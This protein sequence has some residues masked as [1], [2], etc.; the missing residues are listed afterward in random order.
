MKNGLS[1]FN[2]G[3]TAT[4]V[5]DDTPT[6]T[7]TDTPVGQTIA[8]FRGAAAKKAPL[9]PTQ[10]ADLLANMQDMIDSRQ[11]PMA[12]FN[13]GLERAAAWG[14]GGIQGPSAA[15]NQLNQ[16][17]MAEQKSTFE[18]RQQM[19]AYRAAQ[20]QA[21]ADAEQVGKFTTPS[22]TGGMQ[23]SPEAQ[24]R[25]DLERNPT[26]RLA[27]INEDLKTRGSERAKAEFNPA[28]LKAEEYVY[29][30]DPNTNK[31]EAKQV[32]LNTYLDL[33]AKG[34]IVTEAEMLMGKGQKPTA[35]APTTTPTTAPTTA[36]GQA[37]TPSYLETP[38]AKIASQIGTTTGDFSPQEIDRLRVVESGKDPFA[39]NKDSKA[40]GPY[41][42][43]PE[44]VQDL[45]KRGIKFNPFDAEES[46]TVA[47]NELNRLTKLL[48]SKELALASYGG[49]SQ[50]DPTGYIGK[51]LVTPAGTVIAPPATEKPSTKPQATISEIKAE[52]QFQEDYNKGVAEGLSKENATALAKFKTDTNKFAISEELVTAKRIQDLAKNNPAITG[53]M[54]NAGLMPAIAKILEGGVGNFGIKE[55]DEALFLSKAD[56]SRLS[57]AERNELITYMA[58]I[59]LKAASLIKGQGQITEGEREILKRAS[60]S[61]K[62]P[63]EAVFKKARMLEA[64]AKKHDEMRE[65][66]AKTPG[67]AKNRNFEKFMEENPQIQKLHVQYR[68]EL[69]EILNEKVDFS[70][71]RAAAGKTKPVQHPKEVQA[72]I[73]RNKPGA[74]Q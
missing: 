73:D 54:Q 65:I 12:S 29:I 38:A 61:I 35:T 11:G 17:E 21:K 15:L 39:L 44:T 55:I 56:T 31:I 63:A 70:K 40:M 22:G 57:I 24:A 5:V 2:R 25:F 16:Q 62:D 58:R 32:S 41:Q 4:D 18:M 69:S 60:S 14:S 1:Y 46:R 50:K 26:K 52:K 42:F 67:T 37:R 51:I 66:Y 9:D 6:D 23:L 10:T 72:I 3:G 74:K 33:K 13:R 59:E 36:T 28:S 8:P 43:L 20:E 30:R 45:H 53:V 48:G 7:P 34:L 19:A 49:H 27:I 68:Q 47:T 71:Q 64:L